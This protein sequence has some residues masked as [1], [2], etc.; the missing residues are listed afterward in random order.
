M[1]SLAH[2]MFPAPGST[3]SQEASEVLQSPRPVTCPHLSLPFSIFFL[4]AGQSRGMPLFRCAGAGQVTFNSGWGLLLL[5]PQNLGTQGCCV[6][7]EQQVDAPVLS[8]WG[9]VGDLAGDTQNAAGCDE[10]VST[11]SW[12]WSL[13]SWC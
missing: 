5:E 12:C 2:W 8:L 7:F 4:F 10:A 3:V 11:Q 6:C 1:G 13:V 9:A